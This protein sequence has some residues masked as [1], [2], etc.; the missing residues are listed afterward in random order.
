MNALC[1]EGRGTLFEGCFGVDQFADLGA[2][3]LLVLVLIVLPI[4]LLIAL[5]LV[6]LFRARVK[7][8]MRA[9]AG[10]AVNPETYQRPP[11]GPPGELGVAVLRVTRDNSRAARSTPLVSRLRARARGVALVYGGAACLQSLVLA[12]VLVASIQFAPTDNVSLK[13]ALLFIGFF[14]VNASPVVLAP[15]I[16]V[17]RQLSFLILAVLALIVVLWAFDW[18]VGGD[19]VGLWLLISGVATGA[20]LLLNIRPLRAVGPIVF[21]AALMFSYSAIG[22]HFYAT[23]IVWKAI[24]PVHFVRE[25]LAPLPLL[26]GMQKYLDEIARLPGPEQLAAVTTVL[27]EPTSLLRA[28]HPEAITTTVKLEV[29][30]LSLAAIVLGALA[31][32]A[33]VRWLAVHYHTR[34]ASDQM[35]GVDVLMVIFAL[36]SLLS[37]APAFGWVA[38][39]SAIPA[40]AGYSLG[41][42]YG[43]RRR[44]R[45]APPVEPRTLLLFRVF[46]FD[47]RTQRLLQDLG[48]RWRYLGP[49]R[50]M[51][52]VDLA[53]S[54]LEPH[55]FFDFL[56]GRLTRAFV[57]NRQDLEQRLSEHLPV[58]DPDGLF[59]VQEFYCHENTWR[60]TAS[61]V[62]VQADAVLMDLRSFSPSNRGCIFEIEQLIAS[63]SVPRIVLLIDRTTDLPFLE[64]TLQNAWRAMP[65]DSPNYRAGGHRLRV[66]HA[67]AR[68]QRD[69]DTLIGLLCESMTLP[70]TLTP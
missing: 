21:A 67:S 10:E 43:L 63:V 26:E 53:D 58:P 11:D 37:L 24:G 51:G 54:T 19:V 17:K 49:I 36:S 9:T 65:G 61:Y 15:T 69:V 8:S 59:R 45:L 7:Q 35:L 34:R 5:A 64:Q 42:R 4:A 66:L 2:A 22:G 56:N 25:D 28:A 50:L 31:S 32:F 23:A 6:R 16:I 20:I 48:Q 70:A 3:L 44:Q 14:L 41:A 13:F 18:A 33:C 40:F 29:V 55:E 38:G 1:S 27:A 52:G 12:A 46:G 62:A 47:R 60:M 68:H 57:R 30:G 39:A